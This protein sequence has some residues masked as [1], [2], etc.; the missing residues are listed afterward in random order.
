MDALNMEVLAES[1]TI[2]SHNTE[3]SKQIQLPATRILGIAL[4]V[5]YTL[6]DGGVA[7]NENVA[8]WLKHFKIGSQGDQPIEVYSDE[9]V[10][11]A[12]FASAGQ[13]GT[14][15]YYDA[16]PTTTVEQTAYFFIEGP[17]QLKDMVKP[18]AEIAFRKATDEWG[19]ATAM[20]AEM[21]IG[22]IRDY[23]DDISEPGVYFERHLTPAGVQQQI[24][25]GNG[26]VDAVYL[27]SSAAITDL[28]VAG[29]VVAGRSASNVAS[30]NDMTLAEATWA[31]WTQSTYTANQAVLLLRSEYFPG[32]EIF[33]NMTS[34]TVLAIA[35]NVQ[36]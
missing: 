2:A 4:I 18:V 35:R 25:I 22:I 16:Q 12:E 26:Y 31:A 23:N 1:H 9:I 11:L 20:A 19:G 3:I 34:G 7:A 28:A 21:K 32:R 10:Q 6:T 33:V 27:E 5:K 13:V 14:G 36:V 24:P 29:Q 8:G 30:M 15:H 17:F